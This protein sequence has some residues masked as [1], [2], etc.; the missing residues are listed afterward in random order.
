[1]T[2]THKPKQLQLSEQS[3]NSPFGLINQNK[4]DTMRVL[5][6]EQHLFIQKS[7]TGQPNSDRRNLSNTWWARQRNP[8]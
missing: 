4:Q 8:N 2:N 5:L 1:M 6:R 3:P 7:L